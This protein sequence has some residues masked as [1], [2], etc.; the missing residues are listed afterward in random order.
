M[1][2]GWLGE[3]R[4]SGTIKV[5]GIFSAAGRVVAAAQKKRIV[6]KPA[7]RRRILIGRTAT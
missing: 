3:V 6:K 1:V 7:L 5:P 2:A 4:L